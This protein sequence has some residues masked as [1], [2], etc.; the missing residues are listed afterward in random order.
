MPIYEYDCKGC[1]IVEAIQKFSDG[2]L[3]NCPKCDSKEI[4]KIVSASAFHLKG[5]G[6]YKTDYKS[7][8]TTTSPKPSSDSVKKESVAETTSSDKT[9]TKVEA[10]KETNKSL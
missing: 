6:W 4:K 3:T 7:T 5:Q 8:S 9:D 1:G 10:V 2:P